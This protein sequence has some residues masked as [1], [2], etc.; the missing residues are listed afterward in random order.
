VTAAPLLAIDTASPLVSVA[1]TLGD[2]VLAA[3]AG[4]QRESSSR[5]IGWIDEALAEAGVTLGALGGAVAVRGPGS[6][7]GLRV[8]LATLLGFHQAIGLP[9]TAL[10]TLEVLAAAVAPGGRA[11]N[12]LSLVP[13]GPT[14]WFAQV[15]AGDWPPR[16]LGEP[17]RVVTA[18][19]GAIA[20]GDP[21]ENAG[22]PAA[23]DVVAVA[24]E[25]QRASLPDLG[26]H[27]E[28]TGALATVAGR[29]VDRHPRGWDATLLSAPLYLAPAPVTVPGAPKAVLPRAP[30][31]AR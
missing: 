6:F 26:W 13:A 7:T 18:R 29:L 23:I 5:L 12:V 27:V 22:E 24:A 9:V 19:L 21:G 25:E 17:R 16:A 28:V 2:R 11:R 30:E 1:V 3:R 8:G 4:A 15:F 20:A 31:P 10:P 14:D